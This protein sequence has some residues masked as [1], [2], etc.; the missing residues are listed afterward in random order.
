MHA[1]IYVR[2]ERSQNPGHPGPGPGHQP[3]L[4]SESAAAQSNK[5][6]G[7]ITVIVSTIVTTYPVSTSRQPEP[8][9]QKCVSPGVFRMLDSYHSWAEIEVKSRDHK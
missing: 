5:G 1:C 2:Q 7:L 4:P 9:E 8:G 3:A 6:V